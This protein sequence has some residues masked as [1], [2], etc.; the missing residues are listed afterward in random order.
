MNTDYLELKSLLQK[1]SPLSLEKKDF[2]ERSEQIEMLEAVS[3]AF[4]EKKIAFIEAGTGV[5]K[6]LAYLLP[7]I[8]HCK[9][10]GK[11]C[12]ISTHTITLQE[13]LLQKDIPFILDSLG[14][15]LEVVL[16]KGMSNY[17][18]LR[19]L[20]DQLDRGSL[21]SLEQ[22][23]ELEEVQ[24]WVNKTS[25]GSLSDI[26]KMPQKMGWDKLN[27]ESDA[28]SFVKCP[29]YRECF[30]FKARKKCKD[31]HLLIANHALILADIGSKQIDDEQSSIL[32]DYEYLIL[33]EAHTFED[34]ATQSLASQVSSNAI[35]KKLND[36]ISERSSIGLLS[37]LKKVLYEFKD[38]LNPKLYDEVANDFP[39]DK[40]MLQTNLIESFIAFGEFLD[41][42]LPKEDLSYQKLTLTQPLRQKEEFKN[43]EDH[44]EA[45][46]D[47]MKGFSLNLLSLIDRCLEIKNSDLKKRTQNILIDLKAISNFFEKISL[48]FWDFFHPQDEKNKLYV[49]EWDKAKSFSAIKLLIIHLNISE[50][51]AKHLFAPRESA[52]LCSATLSLNN[53]FEFIQSQL[54]FKSSFFEKK[55]FIEKELLSPF[56]YR[57]Q[58]LLAIP[59]DMP[60]PRSYDFSLRL[61][62]QVKRALLASQGGAFILF[63]SYHALNDC[64][65]KISDDLIKNGLL[66]LKQGD[67]NRHILLKIF[68]ENSNAVLFG[69][70]TFWEGIDVPGFHLRLVIITKLPFPVPNEPI[71]QSKCKQLEEKGLNP[72]FNY[73]I[74]KALVKFKQ[75][76]G[77]LIRT[78]RDYGCILCLDSRLVSKAYGKLFLESLPCTAKII[79]G[80]KTVSEKM[81]QFYEQ[82]RNW[83]VTDS[84][85]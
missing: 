25:D 33:D 82:K 73:S 56:D 51:L 66:P 39:L 5:G 45:L 12:V 52:V 37:R 28:C 74:P 27:C 32:P 76:F 70:D 78:K 22:K 4:T 15:D 75:G 46:I 31:A 23:S 3:Q 35:L 50:I 65:E 13:Q 2:E 20:Y 63:T 84:N 40:K 11:K 58:A 1:K 24:A 6:S 44:F 85:R 60:D 19:K 43:L 72:F 29:Y 79:S 49:I 77:R 8:F 21:F 81:S 64:Y 41:L 18:C 80:S 48:A 34:I 68:K 54:G 16:V 9:K 42:Q 71:F 26:P 62:E 38:E 7:A 61:V 69:T 17:L 59:S 14:I 36:L 10:T 67:E 30:F 47:Q 83:S 55:L 57:N 53:S